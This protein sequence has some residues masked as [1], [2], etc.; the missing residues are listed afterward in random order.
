MADQNYPIL[1]WR[2]D[3]MAISSCH[4]DLLYNIGCS[5]AIQLARYLSPFQRDALAE[6]G[7]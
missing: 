5:V 4:F 7:A 6:I 1:L 3:E 2:A